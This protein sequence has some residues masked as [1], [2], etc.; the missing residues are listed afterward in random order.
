MQQEQPV[1]AAAVLA[2]QGA[3]ANELHFPLYIGVVRSVLHDVDSN[4]QT[5]DGSAGGP[6]SAALA[7]CHGFLQELLKALR[8]RQAVQG[9]AFRSVQAAWEAVHFSM[10]HARC[11]G[12]GWLEL[13]AL[14]ATS[15]LRAAGGLIPAD[16]AYALAGRWCRAAT[17][18]KVT[19]LLV[20]GKFWK[21]KGFWMYRA[22]TP[23]ACRVCLASSG[24]AQHGAPVLEPLL[25][26]G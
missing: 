21:S 6:S 24:S 15:L 9:A 23:D 14:Q 8:R 2:Q 10:L 20:P 16:R 7:A 12:Q 17:L 3:P 5:S 18:C 25:G 26:C 13:A 1:A 11:A 4:Q 22:V 19:N